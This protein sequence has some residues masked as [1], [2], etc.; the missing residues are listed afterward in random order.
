M[1]KKMKII[2][3]SPNRRS[4]SKVIWAVLSLREGCGGVLLSGPP[5]SGLFSK[6][7]FGGDQPSSET[8]SSSLEKWKQ[9]KT[10][11]VNQPQRPTL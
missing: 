8:S 1:L 2:P 5:I 11:G 7:T 10:R 3:S 9:T 4:S 6:E